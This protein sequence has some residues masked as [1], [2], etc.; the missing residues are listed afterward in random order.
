MNRKVLAIVLITLGLCTAAGAGIY[1]YNKYSNT[2]TNPNISIDS[3]GYTVTVD[4]KY[5]STETTTEQQN[6]VF[7]TPEEAL[8]FLE[9][10]SIIYDVD[11]V[12]GF[13]REYCTSFESNSYDTV[14]GYFA[15]DLRDIIKS[16]DLI[17]YIDTTDKTVAILDSWSFSPENNSLYNCD[18]TLNVYNKNEYDELSKSSNEDEDFLANLT[19]V[20]VI[21]KSDKFTL[22]KVDGKIYI[23]KY[24]SKNIDDNK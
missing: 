23:T 21:K 19:P 6:H 20:K 8:S 15:E 22:N 17:P 7:S 10:S 1:F 12:F 16:S 11:E 18:Y 5:I 4:S 9:N 3:E 2:I 13:L 14:L 24:L